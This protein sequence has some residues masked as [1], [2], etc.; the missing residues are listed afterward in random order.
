MTRVDC[1]DH[2]PAARARTRRSRTTAIVLHHLGTDIDRDGI[3]TKDEAV[4]FF[5][6]DPEGIATVALPGTYDHKLPTIRRWKERGPPY[7][8]VAGADLTYSGFVPYHRLVGV[9]GTVY[10]MLPIEVVGAHAGA[11]NDRSV[12]VACLGDFSKRPPT[13]AEELALIALLRDIL[14]VYPGAEIVS[15]DETLVRAGLEPKGCP[16]KF[17]PLDRVRRDAGGAA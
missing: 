6:K 16:G 17:F 9:D 1:Y 12:G 10:R 7:T 14:S 3:T 2:S 8:T 11:W 13:D 5:V 4:S 15:H